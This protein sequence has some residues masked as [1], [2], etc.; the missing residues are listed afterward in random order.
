MNI[1]ITNDPYVGV[2]SQQGMLSFAAAPEPFGLRV[3]A[4][5]A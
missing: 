1:L 5:A 2:T 4:R 3:R